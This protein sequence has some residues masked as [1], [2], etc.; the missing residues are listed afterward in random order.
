MQILNIKKMLYNITCS[1]I[2]CDKLIVELIDKS[3]RE[4]LRNSKLI[5]LGLS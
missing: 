1:L 3:K 2:L 5:S 4:K